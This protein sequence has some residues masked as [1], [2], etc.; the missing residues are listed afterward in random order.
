VCGGEETGF[1][2]AKSQHLLP[3]WD[4]IVNMLVLTKK[5]EATACILGSYPETDLLLISTVFVTRPSKRFLYET[6]KQNR[7]KTCLLIIIILVGSTALIRRP[8]E[9][10]SEYTTHICR[11]IEYQ[12]PRHL[13]NGLLSTRNY[14]TYPPAHRAAGSMAPIC[15]HIKYQDP[16][17]LSTGPLSTRIHGYLPA[18]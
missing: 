12:D 9:Y 11:H 6:N 15:R 13:S 10:H 3:F 16:R 8:F 18:Y 2:P 5:I 4:S 7:I 17:H 14:G 1:E